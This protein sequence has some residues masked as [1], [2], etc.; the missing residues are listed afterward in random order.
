VTKSSSRESDTAVASTAVQKRRGSRL[1]RVF[2]RPEAGAAVGAVAVFIFFVIFGG[3]AG[4]TNLNGFASWLAVAAELGIMALPVGLLMI[5]GEFD[6]SIGSV[7]ACSSMIVAISVATFHL[8]LLVGVVLA[9]VFGLLVGLVNGLLVVRTG[10]PSFI[11]T[12]VMLFSLAGLALAVSRAIMGTTSLSMKT[13]GVVH[14]IFG[15]TM[16]PF[17]ASLIWWVVIAIGASYVLQAT[18]FGNWVFA[19]GGD[20]ETARL[21]GVPTSRVKIMLY[22]YSGFSAALVGTIQAIEFSNADVTRGQGFVFQAI[23]AAVVGGCLL[24]GGYGSA[25]GIVFGTI[26]YSVI[27]IGIFYTGWNPDLVQLFV[28]VLL[29]F[30]VIGNNYVRRLALSRP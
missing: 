12:L 19:V 7:F 8:P 3:R 13:G 22:M 25:L 28:G 4:F 23:V 24:S 20:R 6:L 9:L 29:F 21:S 15:G 1:A 16:G 18:R 2:S 10:L 14:A 27:S 26:T 30:A 17:K 11:V 5:A